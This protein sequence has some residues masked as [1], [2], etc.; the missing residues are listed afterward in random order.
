MIL[1]F[2]IS[3]TNVALKDELF[4]VS[5]LDPH[6]KAVPFLSDVVSDNTFNR[7]LAED[8]CL[9]Q[10]YS[11]ASCKSIEEKDCSSHSKKFKLLNIFFWNQQESDGD[12]AEDTVA[13]QHKDNYLG[14]VGVD[15][16]PTPPK[17][18]TNLLDWCHLKLA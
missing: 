11:I 12:G 17:R 1:I 2:E 4:E 13:V 3:L 7:L 6:I 8:A 5:A 9:E 15:D 18:P 16:V 10:V 14:H